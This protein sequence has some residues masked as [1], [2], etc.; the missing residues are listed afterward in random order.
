MEEFL[1]K[2][3]GWEYFYNLARPHYGKG[4]GE[5]AFRE[6]S[7]WGYDLPEQFAVFPPDY[8]RHY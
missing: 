1:N 8:F 6:V 4:M 5:D 3:A 2:V 7:E